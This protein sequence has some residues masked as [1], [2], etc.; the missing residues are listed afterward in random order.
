PP[1]LEMVQQMVA[2]DINTPWTSSCGRLFD[3]VSALL[4]M[5]LETSYEAQAAIELEMAA[6]DV[7][8]DTVQPYPFSVEK[9]AQGH[10]VR[11]E[12]LLAAIVRA[13]MAGVSD[14]EISAS[15]HITLAE[16]TLQM[17]QM[18]R[19]ETGLGAVALSGGCFQ[20]R[21]LLRLTTDALQAQGFRVLLHRQVPCNDGGLSLGQAVIGH[22]LNGG[23]A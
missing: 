10:V 13:T 9:Q 1:E 15:F 11:L 19:E 12:A 3:A 6:G 4:G 7:Q 5:R 18:V 17:C 20:N 14:G 23:N 8:R 2:R 22:F 21:Q 16:M